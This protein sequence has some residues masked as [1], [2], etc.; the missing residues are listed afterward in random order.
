MEKE[1]PVKPSPAPVAD[2]IVID[3][4]DAVDVSLKTSGPSSSK[5][6]G[7]SPPT[8]DS[9][10]KGKKKQGEGVDFQGSSAT[11]SH[12]QFAFVLGLISF[13]LPPPSSLVFPLKLT[14][15]LFAL[16]TTKKRTVQ[17][18]ALLPETQR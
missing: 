3:H 4:D 8:S 10:L 16:E 7:T 5:V 17:Y 9:K 14:H 11:V 15:P 13:P 1:T 18:L 12:V 6:A 2:L